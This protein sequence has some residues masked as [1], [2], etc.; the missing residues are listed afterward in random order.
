MDFGAQTF[1][2]I[3]FRDREYILD[4]WE[5]L[6]GARLT[7]TFARIGGVAKDLPDGFVERCRKVADFLPQRLSE[8]ERLIDVNRIF[9]KRAV[10]VG[11]FPADE[12]HA[13]RVTGPALRSAGVARDL[14]KDEPYAAYGEIDFEVAV[15][16]D[17]DVYARYRVRMKEMYESCKIIRQCLDNL[18]DGDY[19]ASDAAHVLP[20]KKQ[21][22]RDAAA[23]VQDFV[24]VFHGPD[25][26]QGEVYVAHEAP[27][28]E[29]AV[30]A[31]S[32]GGPKPQRLRFSTPSFYHAQ[33]VPP[34]FEGEMIADSVG[35]FGSLDVVLGDVDR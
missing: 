28:G 13:W 14:R 25:A 17:A 5:M 30:Y 34:M 2:L 18:P 27:K 24:H 29:M 32:D 31:V 23:M 11:I 33:V 16:Y 4:L 35:I 10:G 3:C 9:L 20:R 22:L 21:V 6:S 19:I 7:H 1:F 8:Y 26:P 12:C 15:E